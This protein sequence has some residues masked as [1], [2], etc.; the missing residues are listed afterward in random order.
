MLDARK[1]ELQKDLARSKS[2]RRR[3]MVLERL[4]ATAEAQ[5]T[6][7]E[8]LE[9]DRPTLARW[10]RTIHEGWDQIATYELEIAKVAREAKVP[11]RDL[12]R[13]IRKVRRTPD[14]HGREVVEQTGISEETWRDYDSRVRRQ[15]RKIRKVEMLSLIHI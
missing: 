3:E 13:Y 14:T 10:S 8:R 7:L 5:Y 6:L 11:V 9:P 4:E 12:R 15:L 2:K 1:K